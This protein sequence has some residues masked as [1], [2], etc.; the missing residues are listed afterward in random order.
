MKFLQQ[1][2]FFPFANRTHWY[3]T[4]TEPQA[5]TDQNF[6]NSIQTMHSSQQLQNH[7]CGCKGLSLAPWTQAKTRHHLCPQEDDRLPRETDWL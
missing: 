7:Y 2:R 6:T 5:K 1:S 3:E 4:K